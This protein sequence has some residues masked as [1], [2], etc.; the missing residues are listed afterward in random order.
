MLLLSACGGGGGG[1][2]SG[3]GGGGGGPPPASV[4]V[5]GRITYDRVPFEACADGTCRDGT[6]AD[7]LDYVNTQEAPARAVTVELVNATNR[8]VLATVATDASG[9]YTLTAPPNTSAFVRAKAVSVST[10]SGAASW[11]IRV[12][13]NFEGANSLYAVEGSTFDTSVVNHTRNLRAASGWNG[14]AGYSSA[15]AAAP[16]AILDTLY[17]AVQFVIAQGDP[18]LRLGPLQVFWSPEN[19]PTNEWNP[20]RGWIVTTAY[21]SGS[22]AGSAPAGIYVLGA[23]DNDIDEYDQHI[24]AHE[25]QHF[26]EDQVSRSDTP[27]GPHS[28]DEQLDMRVSFSEGFA[29]AFSAMVLNDPVYRDAFGASQGMV[30][31]FDVERGQVAS[32][33]WFNETSVQAIAWDLFDAANDDNVS[34]GYGPMHRVLRDSMRDGTPLTSIFSFITPLKGIAGVPAAAVDAR[35]EAESIVSTT[36]DAYATTETHYGPIAV[37]DRSK[38]LPMYTDIAPNGAAVRIC[39][40][41]PTGGGYNKIG[42]RRFLEVQRAERTD[43]RHPGELPGDRPD[44]YRRAHARTRISRCPGAGRSN[45]PKPRRRTSSS[46]RK[47]W[48]RGITCS[49]STS[50]VT[51]IPTRRRAS[52]RYLHDRSHHRLKHLHHDHQQHCPC[53]CFRVDRARFAGR[54]LRRGRR[55]VGG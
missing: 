11:D 13:N 38:V 18:A 16:F 44:L 26:L 8:T 41:L 48:K 46:C 17:A 39:G 7:G 5:S 21:R 55:E 9:N 12:L 33:G 3:G 27:G 6:F 54:G 10:G 50:T 4:T 24:V 2:S 30:Y 20:A 49:K 15:R 34:I 31:R 35:V 1:S 32:R 19:R 28:L 51:R 40:G 52:R 53:P 43:A 22:S 47:M 14:F 29:N 42:N 45:L 25:F 23:A 36:M 37:A